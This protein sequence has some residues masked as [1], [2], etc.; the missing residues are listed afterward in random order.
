MVKM[1]TLTSIL[2]IIRIMLLIHNNVDAPK[3]DD[4]LL[5]ITMLSMLNA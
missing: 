2:M 4:A 3:N 1:M 5:R